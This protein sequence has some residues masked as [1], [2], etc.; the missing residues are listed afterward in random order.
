MALPYG[1]Q[2]DSLPK[3]GEGSQGKVYRIDDWRCIKVY[4]RT[5]FLPLELEILLKAQND[6]LA[7]LFFPRVYEW[8]PDYIIREFI[9]GSGFKD[10]LRK[11][12]LTE[13]LSRQLV[14]MF[15]AFE[16]LEFRRMDTRMAH[17]LVTSDGRIKAIDPANAMQK[18]GSYPRKLL[19]QLAK[20]KCKNTF[21]NHVKAISPAL[22]E[23]WR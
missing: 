1:I 4:F 23:A 10:Y 5:E 9:C 17:I 3:V 15:Q 8:G 18:S 20:L 19:S 13:D 14:L 6:P 11:H 7:S 21:L 12:P 2:L 22:Y 16:R